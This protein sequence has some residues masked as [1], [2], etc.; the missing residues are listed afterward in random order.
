[1]LG[2][3]VRNAPTFLQKSAAKKALWSCSLCGVRVTGFDIIPQ[4]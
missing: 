2:I 3:P 1:M 4:P